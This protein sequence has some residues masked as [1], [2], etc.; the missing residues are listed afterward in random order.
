MEQLMYA[1]FSKAEELRISCEK[2]TLQL[3][4]AD[5]QIQSV[6]MTGSG[7]GNVLS[8]VVDARISAEIRFRNDSPGPALPEAVK[9]ALHTDIP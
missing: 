5:G 2:G 3:A 6:A 8:A 1:V 9:H 4:I 7:S